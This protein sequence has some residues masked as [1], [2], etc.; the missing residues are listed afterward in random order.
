MRG[1]GLLAAALVLAL[2]PWGAEAALP[3]DPATGDTVVTVDTT[4]QN[5]TIAPAKNLTV[6]A[7]ATLTLIDC[8]VVLNRYARFDVIGSLVMRNVTI[9]SNTTG[10]M[11]DFTCSGSVDMQYCTVSNSMTWSLNRFSYG[12]SV[13]NC[14]FDLSGAGIDIDNGTPVLRGNR[15]AAGEYK[16]YLSPMVYVRNA[17]PVIERNAFDG[18]LGQYDGLVIFYPDSPVISN[19]TFL[20][21]SVGLQY[22]FIHQHAGDGTVSPAPGEPALLENNRFQACRFGLVAADEYQGNG[23]GGRASLSRAR[24]PPGPVFLARGDRFENNSYGLYAIN[25]APSVVERCEFTGNGGGIRM[26]YVTGMRLEND[27]FT[28]NTAGIETDGGELGLAGCDFNANDRDLECWDTASVIEGN[29]FRGGNNASVSLSRFTATGSYFANNTVAGGNAPGLRIDG[30]AVVFN[31]TFRDCP[32]GIYR[33]VRQ[34]GQGHG[35]DIQQPPG[36]EPDMAIIANNRFENNTRGIYS[37]GYTNIS[38]NDF[39]GNR[40]GVEVSYFSHPDDNGYGGYRDNGIVDRFTVQSNRFTGNEAGVLLLG[41]NYHG[42]DSGQRCIRDNA[43]TDNTFGID[44]IW[45]E[46]A[47]GANNFSR[48]G[49]WAFRQIGDYG[50]ET[51][52]NEFGECDRLLRQGLFWLDVYEPPDD[53]PNAPLR[54][55][56]RS[57][58]ASVR[59]TARSGE[60]TFSG[61]THDGHP[62]YF[63]PDGFR[64]YTVNLTTEMTMANGSVVK[65][66][67]VL[68][69]AWKPGK[70]VANETV[71]LDEEDRIELFLQP[72]PDINVTDFGFAASTAIAG[73]RLAGNFT[74]L[75]DNA[76]DPTNVSM[77]DVAVDVALDG[78]VVQTMNIPWLRSGVP[79]TRDIEWTATPG[80]HTWTVTADPRGRFRELDRGNNIE[81]FT[82]DVNGRPEAVISAEP[83]GGLTSEPVNFSGAGS[84]DDGAVVGFRF[85]FGDGTV[86]GWS[87]NSTAVHSYKRAGSYKARLKVRDDLGL[88]SDWSAPWGV[89]IGNR[90]PSLVIV[91]ENAEVLT[92]EPANFTI[93]ASDPEDSSFSVS[94]DFGDGG[95]MSGRDLFSV[96]HEYAGDGCFSVHVS[97]RDSDDGIV[98]TAVNITVRN[99]PPAALFA[100]SPDEGTVLTRFS[101]LPMGSDPDGRV[102]SFLWDFGDHCSSRIDRPIH[103][104]NSPGVY[105]ASLTVNDDD[106]A[107]SEPF[108]L[109]VTVS[110]TPPVARV[111]LSG[112]APRVGQ[113]LKFDASASFDAEDPPWNISWDFGDGR[114][115]VGV[116]VEH[117]FRRPGNYTVR[118]RVTDAHGASSEAV[119]QVIVRDADAGAVDDGWRNAALGSGL[120]TISGAVFL[121]WVLRH[122]PAAARPPRHR[123]VRSVQRARDFDVYADRLARSRTERARRENS[124]RSMYDAMQP[125]RDGGA[126]EPGNR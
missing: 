12:C 91:A 72:A 78:T 89:P 80:N 86:S 123:A 44:Q 126:G 17:A 4:V 115:A 53:D 68:A 2:V 60:A 25:E 120:M 62:P 70:G 42:M 40:A 34:Y 16:S 37:E 96:S 104:Y 85:D 43:F 27:T 11:Y 94:W 114:S 95:R 13:I 56:V 122:R 15:F 73:E 51:S 52:G 1:K 59:I 100:V 97:I 121:A 110:N 113:A 50:P 21:C 57:D 109:A 82:V 47:N 33:A 76:Y 58:H 101:F 38:E 93:M 24:Q 45:S 28:N 77:Q 98:D 8:R 90:L 36:P 20:N 39:T 63:A 23:R 102:L 118:V 124:N 107:P 65:T 3:V 64:F 66:S 5:E 74:V 112:G 31:N 19:N 71:G 106:G 48:N 111:R 84:R 6:G 83:A 14:T 54:D 81:T 99:R 46:A 55:Y 61:T 9:T 125:V 10:P 35:R 103:S 92:L 87:G 32:F 26:D 108:T 88:E 22:F 49:G 75:N 29:T 119:L 18:R 69:E 117:A 105:N 30:T 7:G 79:E 67:P 41:T 116:T